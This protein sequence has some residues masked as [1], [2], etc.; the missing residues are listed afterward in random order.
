MGNHEL[1]MIDTLAPNRTNIRKEY[2]WMYNWFNNGGRCTYIDFR[3][4]PDEIK[5]SILEYLTDSPY[6]R[7]LRVGDRDFYIVHGGPEGCN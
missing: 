1:M 2:D 3:S 4:R 7:Y 5:N 6:E